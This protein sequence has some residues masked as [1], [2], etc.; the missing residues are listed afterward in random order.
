MTWCSW[1]QRVSAEPLFSRDAAHPRS[2]ADSE[3]QT[4]RTTTRHRGK[5]PASSISL[6]L[7]GSV[8]QMSR[9]WGGSCIGATREYSSRCITLQSDK[10]YLKAIHALVHTRRHHV[11]NGSMTKHTG[12]IERRMSPERKMGKEVAET[13]YLL[14]PVCPNL[15]GEVVR[16]GESLLDAKRERL[17][18][19]ECLTQPEKSRPD[20]PLSISYSR[21]GPRTAFITKP[22][23]PV[24]ADHPGPSALNRPPCGPA[25]VLAARCLRLT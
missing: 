17:A 16:K 10:P 12:T 19:W 18:V 11:E 20:L 7:S 3:P 15:G 9:R 22:T 13:P 8:V 23:P 14:A 25:P 6:G 5:G 24:P 4:T 1:S 21:E 2:A